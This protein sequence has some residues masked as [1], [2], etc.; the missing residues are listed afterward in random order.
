MAKSINGD[1]KL[2]YIQTQRQYFDARVDFFRAPVPAA[3]AERTRAIVASAG[4]NEN[5]RV[6]DVGTGVGVLVAHFLEFGVSAGNIVG[7]DLSQEML[8]GAKSRFPE[9][10]FYQSDIADLHLPL[11]DEFPENLR[12]AQEIGE[13]PIKCF[14]IVFF[15]AC[16]GN[17]WN[18]QEALMAAAQLLGGRGQIVISHPLGARFVDSLHRNEPHIVPHQLPDEEQLGALCLKSKLEVVSADIRDEFYLVILKTVGV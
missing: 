12:R 5:T 8:R 6:L 9:V 14:E 15:N 10:F 13:D 1:E 11:P 18:Q 2:P 4:L 3:I 7:L 16:F 17:M